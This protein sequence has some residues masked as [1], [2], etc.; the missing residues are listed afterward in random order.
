[1]MMIILFII[2][3]LSCYLA[4]K[5]LLIYPIAMSTLEHIMQY[6]HPEQW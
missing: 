2:W 1:M 3:S 6:I 5:R 4:K